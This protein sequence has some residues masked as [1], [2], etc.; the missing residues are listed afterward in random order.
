ME[1]YSGFLQQE[2]SANLCQATVLALRISGQ[3]DIAAVEDQ[4]MMSFMD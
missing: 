4:P 1:F 3:A 2:I